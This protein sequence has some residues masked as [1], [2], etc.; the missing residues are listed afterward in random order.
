MGTLVL[1]RRAPKTQADL[2]RSLAAL[3][4]SIWQAERIIKW[5]ALAES[6]RKQRR[7]LQERYEKRN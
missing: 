4:R 1:L 3:D 7:E 2:K 6:F 5:T